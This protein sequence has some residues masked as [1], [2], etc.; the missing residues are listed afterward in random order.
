MHQVDIKIDHRSYQEQGIELIP[1]IHQ[2]RNVLE[3]E[4]RGI[5]T[6]LTKEA[7]SIR[8]QN[9]V[10]ICAKPH[11]LLDKITTQQETFTPQT[12]AQEL[13]RYTSSGK[14]FVIDTNIISQVLKTLEHHESVFKETD[15]TKALLPFTQDADELVLALQAIKASDQLIYLGVGEDGRDRFTSR[16]MLE[17]ENHI[18]NIADKLKK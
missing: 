10:R 11:I 17:L 3:M 18:Q 7:N 1:T 12:I 8:K 14:S 15:L 9:L 2:G 5:A 13:G 6:E 4:A 16:T